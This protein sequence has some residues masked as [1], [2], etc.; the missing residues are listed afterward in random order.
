MTDSS[1]FLKLLG[2]V[3][4]SMASIK[5]ADLSPDDRSTLS[6]MIH[7]L[8]LPLE[9]NKE[10]N[11]IR[12]LQKLPEF[13]PKFDL[14]ELSELMMIFSN[15]KNL[16]HDEALHDL[17]LKWDSKLIDLWPQFSH[18]NPFKV[19]PKDKQKDLIINFLDKC[20]KSENCCYL[21]V[22]SQKFHLYPWSLVHLE[23]ELKLIA[24][25]VWD[26]TIT[27]LALNDVDAFFTSSHKHKTIRTNLEIDEFITAIRM[28]SENE[29]RL[30]LKIK[31]SE[32][33]EL[34]P[35]YHF[36]GKPY[37]LTNPEGDLI[38][39]AYVE[40]CDSLFSW[41]AEIKDQ[42]EIMDPSDF[43]QNFESYLKTTHKK[44]A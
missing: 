34:F 14:V 27:S 8:G 6:Q 11:Q 2:L 20:I 33:I 19:L 7:N 24:E 9:I 12:E 41:I 18:F 42:V 4:D 44:A 1:K 3:K 10:Q 16:T 32:N 30:I 31:D 5:L 35:Q 40:P 22:R 26:K 25:D 23:G 29:V 17:V 36:L 13:H 38:W 37:M 28:M 39:S 15:L 21:S 43:K